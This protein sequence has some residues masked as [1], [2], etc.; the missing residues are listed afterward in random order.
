MHSRTR[1]FLILWAA[2]L[3]GV[4]SFLFVDL[5]TLI[6]SFPQ[7]PGA[8]PV[9]LPPPVLLK[10]ASVVQPAILTTFAVLIGC[11]LAPKVALHAPAA[12]AA[13]RGDGILANLR[14]QIAPGVLAGLASGVAI[15]ATWVVAKP[16]LTD[17]FVARAQEFN[18]F[19]PSVT[20]FLYGGVTEELLLRWGLMTFLVWAS[21]RLFQKGKE[22]PTP[23][24]IIAS[25]FIS[26]LIFGIGHLPIAS[27]LAGG[28]TVPLAAYVVAGNSIFGI[29]A[30]F[31]YWRLGL[32]AAIVAHMS[33]HVVL[34]GAIQLAF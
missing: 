4:A 28:L 31:L 6:A 12:E 17:E 22:R 18:K 19:L 25:I 33:A 21:W 20:R 2:G 1:S 14:P 8:P 11:W 29:V 24:L 27:M 32:E 9:E 7:P 13:A 5:Y 16:F 23:I 30:G 3:L 34:I 15:V 26:A 10:I